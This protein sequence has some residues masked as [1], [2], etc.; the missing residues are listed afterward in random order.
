MPTLELARR[1]A[2][3][4]AAPTPAPRTKGRD[5]YFDNVKYAAIV[6]VVVGHSWELLRGESRVLEA[7]YLLLYAFH[8]PAFII[9]SGY[10]SRNFRT[11]EG[12][13]G[14]LVATVLVPYLVFELAYTL[15]ERAFADPGQRLTPTDP[16][17]LMWFLAALFIWRLTTPIWLALRRPVLIAFAL[18]VVGL[19]AQGI[20]NDFQ[21][22]RVLQFLPFFVLGLVLKPEHFGLIRRR[23]TRLLALPV[24]AAAAVLA[25]WAVPRMSTS[26]FYR[27]D[28]VTE[29]EVSAGVG[30]AMAAA[31][32]VC[33]TVLSICFFALVPGRR[34]PVTALGAGTITGYLLHGFVIRG[35]EYAGWHHTHW[36]HTPGGKLAITAAAV[37]GATLLCTRPVHRALSFVVEPK[38]NWIFKD[39]NPE[40][41]TASPRM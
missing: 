2:P 18:S 15:F 24:V 21:L 25:Y 26:W 13:V 8:M 9:I 6:L 12:R 1:Q 36:L 29:L 10:F 7:A 14:R 5:P 28:G 16:Y 22:R 31:L 27:R 20:G 35:V 39:R 23:A 40:T 19:V 41:S 4:G 3:A 37:L 34:L 38:L 11:T 33:S 17:W 30:V 32:F